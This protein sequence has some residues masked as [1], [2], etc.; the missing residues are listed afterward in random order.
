MIVS[1][2]CP[3]PTPLSPVTFVVF[4]LRDLQWKEDESVSWRKRRLRIYDIILTHEVILPQTA[5]TIAGP[6][7]ASPPQDSVAALIWKT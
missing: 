1:L 7:Q 2:K 3:V 4:A 5:Q 6:A